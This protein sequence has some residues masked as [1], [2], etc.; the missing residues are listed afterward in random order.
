MEC[1]CGNPKKKDLECLKVEGFA[2]DEAMFRECVLV[3]AFNMARRDLVRF[4][5][6]LR[7]T[8]NCVGDV[9]VVDRI[10]PIKVSEYAVTDRTG[11]LWSRQQER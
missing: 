11:G 4:Q 2:M 9:Q 7:G 6:W 5:D 10:Q 1:I 3:G 8:R